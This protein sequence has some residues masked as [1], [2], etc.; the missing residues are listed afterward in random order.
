MI[1]DVVVD[2]SFWESPP[3][4]RLY[5]PQLVKSYAGKNSEHA[6]RTRFGRV[7]RQSPGLVGISRLSKDYIRWSTCQQGRPSAGPR[8]VSGPFPMNHDESDRMISSAAPPGVSGDT[9]GLDWRIKCGK[10]I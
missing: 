3:D 2:E 9:N 5:G 7:A 6:P 1:K 10:I 4:L 8:E